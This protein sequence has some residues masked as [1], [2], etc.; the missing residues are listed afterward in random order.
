MK[1]IIDWFKESNRGL[2]LLLGVVV[3]LLPTGWWNTEVLACGVASSMEFKDWQWRAHGG[4]PDPIDFVL[5][6]AGVNIGYLLK[7]GFIATL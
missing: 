2:H 1:K 5:T 7:L 3:G 6:V 4:S